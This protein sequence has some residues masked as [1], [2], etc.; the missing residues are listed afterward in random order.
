[1]MAHRSEPPGV[2][3]AEWLRR[4]C[5]EAGA[6][7]VAFASVDDPALASEV[8]HVAAEA[9]HSKDR[10]AAKHLSRLHERLSRIGETH[11]DA[12]EPLSAAAAEGPSP[13]RY[14]S[15]QGQYLSFIYY[16]T[17][18][19]RVPPAESDLQHCRTIWNIIWTCLVTISAC[20]W[21]TVHPNIPAPDE[22]S[23]AVTCL[24]GEVVLLALI[25]PELI[26]FWAI[27]QWLAARRIVRA[28]VPSGRKYRTKDGKGVCHLHQFHKSSLA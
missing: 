1:M 25:M 24:H 17:K 21:V 3:D 26:F 27:R 8:E 28:V 5:L 23:F 15:K 20:T 11:A 14:T 19:H 10:S 2:I 6:D 4:V 7:D 9:N 12:D 22:S 16:Y 13:P 18:I